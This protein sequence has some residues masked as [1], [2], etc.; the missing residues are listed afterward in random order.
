M[1]TPGLYLVYESAR[2]LGRFAE[3]QELK[4]ALECF[5]RQQREAPDDAD[6]HLRSLKAKR[7]ARGKGRAGPNLPAASNG[8]M[9]EAGG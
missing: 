9:S 1:A 6:P 3:I 4:D 8:S 7:D 5:N 2:D